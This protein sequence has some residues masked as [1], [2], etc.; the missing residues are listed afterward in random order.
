MSESVPYT[1]QETERDIADDDDLEERIRRRAYEISQSDQS[2]TDEEN[3]RRA[4]QEV[5]EQS[6]SQ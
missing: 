1:D 5:R 3:W 6:G 2:G 4:E